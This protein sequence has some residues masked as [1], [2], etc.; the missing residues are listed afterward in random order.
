MSRYTVKPLGNGKS[1]TVIDR[2]YGLDAGTLRKGQLTAAHNMHILS[3]GALHTMLAEQKIPLSDSASLAGVYTPCTE[4]D[5]RYETKVTPEWIYAHLCPAAVLNWPEKLVSTSRILVADVGM[6]GRVNGGYRHPVGAFSDGATTY[7]LYDAVYN[8]IDQRRGEEYS[9][10][11]SGIVAHFNSANSITSDTGSTVCVLTQLWLDRITRTGVTSTLVTATLDKR[12]VLGSGFNKATLVREEGKDFRY[13]SDGYLPDLGASYTGSPDAVYERVYPTLASD[14]TPR[15][16]W[17]GEMRRLVHYNN[18]TAGEG[19][20]GAVGEKLLLLPDGHLLVKGNGGWRFVAADAQ[21][22]AMDAAVQ[23]FDR[24]FGIAG[25]RLYASAAGN[26]ANYVPASDP[27]DTDAAWEAVAPGRGGFTAIAS[28]DGAVV[29]FTATDMMTVRGNALPFS[30]SFEGAYGCPSQDA[31][32]PLGGWL[33][34]V[35]GADVLR[36][37]GSRVESIG[38][39]L[40]R[41]VWNTSAS[42]STADGMLAVRF[43]HLAGLYFYD[44]HSE[45]W[46]FRDCEEA[47]AFFGEGIL[48]RSPGVV[49]VPYRIFGTEGDFSASVSLGALPPRFIRAIG[50]TALLAPLAGLTVADAR[51]KALLVLQ[52]EYGKAVTRTAYFS[53]AEG[54]GITLRGNGEVTVYGLRVESAGKEK[55]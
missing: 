24:L 4:Y 11:G 54:E 17:E 6:P 39:A 53:A 1:E 51:G 10:V 36:Y 50:I 52:G 5:T 16:V 19:E 48:F 33:Y 28:F 45:S 18:R 32:V 3:G 49:S 25:D 55:G 15:S 20:F 38:K 34:F 7:V 37:N 42:L 26:C 31:V 8:I 30:L 23:H 27:T 43:L 47:T 2:F 12:T 22:P 44:P 46:S 29:A 21:M 9:K 13:I 14:Y 35:S 41:E 40:P